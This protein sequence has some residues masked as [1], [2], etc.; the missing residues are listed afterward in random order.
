MTAGETYHI[1]YPSGAFTN[2]GG[3][4]SYVGTAYT[5]GVKPE[6]RELWVWGSNQYNS[7]SAGSLGQNNLVNYSSPVQIP[8]TNWKN[9]AYVN[10]N[11]VLGAK[12]T[13]TDGTLWAWGINE[14]GQLGQNTTSASYPSGFTGAISSPVQIPGTT[15]AIGSGG[16]GVAYTKTDGTLWSWG[17]NNKGSLGQNNLTQYSSPVQIPG[18]TW[19]TS[20]SDGIKLVSGGSNNFTTLAIKTDGTLWIWGYNYAGSLGQNQGTGGLNSA[21]SPVQIPGTTWKSINFNNYSVN[22]IKTDGTLW[23]WGNNGNGGIGANNTTQYSSP[24]Q[25]PGTTWA[26]V[27]GADEMTYA[28]RTDGTLWTWGNNESGSLG[29]NQSAGANSS[30][31]IQV[32]GTTWSSTPMQGGAAQTKQGSVAMKTDGTLWRWGNNNK[33]ALGQNDIVDRSSP[34]QVGSDTTWVQAQIGNVGETYAIKQL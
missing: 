15:W 28:V 27:W 31:P 33:G 20:N 23:G 7:Q 32:P 11:V 26:H 16:R 12:V 25:V 5:F 21:S 34:V 1:S 10:S 14:Y 4:V 3:D 8:G 24:I 18:T 19:P 6:F 9:L 30:S 17:Y 29:H 13:K 2:T 22:A